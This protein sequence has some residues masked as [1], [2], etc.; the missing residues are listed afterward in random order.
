MATPQPNYLIAEDSDLQYAVA[1]LMKAHVSDWGSSKRDWKVEIKIAR[2][3]D[4]ALNHETLFEFMKAGGLRVLGIVV[5]A[6]DKLKERWESIRAFCLKCTVQAPK[7]CPSDGFIVD[8]L[9]GENGIEV[10]FGAWLMPDNND[11]GMIEN[12]CFGL[13]P[14]GNDQLLEHAASS[15]GKAK[16]LGAPFSPTANAKA[17]ARLH[18]W[19]AWQ[20]PP[21]QSLGKAIASQTLR[22]D[23]ESAKP[24]VAWFRKLYGV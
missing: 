14:G 24:F 12:F 22:P 10:K 8:R 16:D 5:D 21:G 20:D 6:D 7:A 18:T 11:G 23:A 3:V 1:E 4:D 2:G 19:L 17:K 9:I 15:I 13:I